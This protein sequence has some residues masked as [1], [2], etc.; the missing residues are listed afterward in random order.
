M[1]SCHP[2]WSHLIRGGEQSEAGLAIGVGLLRVDDHRPEAGAGQGST[3]SPVSQFCLS[4]F[5][6]FL[7]A[8]EWTRM[9]H[10]V[11]ARLVPRARVRSA[12]RESDNIR[13]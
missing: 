7:S 9:S 8:G 3:K 2:P 1:I 13:S 12:L 6:T 11:P 10:T 4:L 5:P